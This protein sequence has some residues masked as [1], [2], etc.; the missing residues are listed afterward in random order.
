MS[1]LYPLSC[2]HKRL[3]RA[4]RLLKANA[5][6]LLRE[7]GETEVSFEGFDFSD[8]FGETLKIRV[9]CGPTDGVRVER[10]LG[11]ISEFWVLPYSNYETVELYK[12]MI[13]YSQASG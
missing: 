13:N 1:R 3:G 6:K 9:E 11:Y 5:T 7:L 8:V 10:S 4:Q 12:F 2:I